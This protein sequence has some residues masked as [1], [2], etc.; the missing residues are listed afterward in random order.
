MSWQGWLQILVF[1]VAIVAA[2]KPLGLYM[3]RVYEEEPIVIDKALGW[4]ERLVYRACGVPL[5][6]EKREMKWTTYAGAMLLFNVVGVLVVYAIQRLQTHL[7]LN[8]DGMGAVSPDLSWNTAIS[9]VT[10]TNWQSYGGETTMSYFT[11]MAALAVQNFVCAASGMA[12]MVALIRGISR[13]TSST[14]GNFWVDL[15]R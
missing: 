3:A 5:D 15:T 4:L 7:P 12:V 8:P 10:N 1:L 14:L 6:R 11:Q 13:K 2:V 9:F